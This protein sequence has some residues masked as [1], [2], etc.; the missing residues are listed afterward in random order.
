MN[1]NIVK[2]IIKKALILFVLGIVLINVGYVSSISPHC[3]QDI[4]VRVVPR[5]VYDQILHSKENVDE[6]FK[7]ML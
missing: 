6:T 3:N 1:K 4:K 2:Y 7:D 5:N